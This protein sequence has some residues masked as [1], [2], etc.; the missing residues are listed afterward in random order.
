MR[1]L[2]NSAFLFAFSNFIPIFAG[3]KSYIVVSRRREQ[4]IMLIW[5]GGLFLC[6]YIIFLALGK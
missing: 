3:V 4:R 1:S 6:P 2:K 5:F